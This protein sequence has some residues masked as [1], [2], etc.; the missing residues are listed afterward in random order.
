[1]TLHTAGPN[2]LARG[3]RAWIVLAGVAALCLPLVVVPVATGTAWSGIRDR[4]S[5]LSPVELAVLVVIWLVGLFA[6]TYVMTGALPDLTHRKAMML[7]FTGSAV[8]QLAPFGGVL[9]M[10]LNYSMLRS[11][12]FTRRHFTHLT[13]L[14][15][16][17]NTAIKLLL[18]SVALAALVVSGHVTSRPLMVAA[19]GGLAALFGI[20]VVTRLALLRRARRPAGE[21]NSRVL[22]ILG[23]LTGHPVH[24]FM[25]AIRSDLHTALRRSW[26]RMTFGA[27]G[28]AFLQAGL[29]YLCVAML[30]SRPS[31]LSVFAAYATGSALTL[32]P[33]TPGGVG[34]SEAGSATL[35]VAL[36]VTPSAAA[37]GVVLYATFT[38]LFEIPVGIAGTAMWWFRRPRWTSLRA[39]NEE[40]EA[41]SRAPV[42]PIYV[43]VP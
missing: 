19:I 40:S 14:T 23:R 13:L 24:E 29:L 8:S 38:R 18:P 26:R 41:T 6:H 42:G 4:V 10:G 32:V 31:L 34:F 15:T 3:R 28:Y 5:G 39:E 35:L 25:A 33:I 11:W 9:G 16:I 22:T 37:A 27:V 7:N 30:G 1:M 43:G 21:M 36:G 20:A 17:F 12:G 2:V